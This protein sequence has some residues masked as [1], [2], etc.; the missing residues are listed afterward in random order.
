[1]NY[2]YQGRL[3]DG[4][5]IAVK[6]LSRNSDQG[7]LEFKN[8]VLFLAKLQHRNVVRLFGFCLDGQEK[9]LLYEFV[10]NASLD[11]F[12]F[13]IIIIIIF[14]LFASFYFLFFR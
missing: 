5:N 13:G 1:M 4:Q 14:K 10:C 7:D 6:R 3:S 2:Y 9:L 8:E 11:R 12:I